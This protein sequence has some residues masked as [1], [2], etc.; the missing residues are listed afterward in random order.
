MQEQ[1]ALEMERISKAFP[2][3]RALNEVS[4][5]V[6]KGTV[7][8]LMGENGAGKST[9]MKILGG[10]Y[11]PDS[12]TIRL[13][14]KQ[15]EMF[16]PR[17]SLKN[18]IS[19]IHQELTSVF[20]MTV[21]E[22]VYLGR[23]PR[24]AN[25]WVNEKKM[26]EDLRKLMQS[27]EI[28]V[29]PKAKMKQLSIAKMQLVEI[30]KAISYNSE[31]IIM[32]EPTSAITN[33]EVDHL[34]KIIRSLTSKGVSIIYISHKMDEIFE[35][36]DDITVLRDGEWVG[37]KAAKDLTQQ[38]LI[39]MMV[40]R[41]L[42]E[43]FP[44]KV[45]EVGEKVLEVKNLSLKGKFHQVSFDLRKGEIL[46]IAGLVGAGRS[47]VMECLFGLAKPDEGEV[48][49]HGKKVDIRS[50][51]E[52]KENHLA[53]ITEDRKLTG[54]F[55]PHSV[56]DN[57]IAASMKKH[58]KGPFMQERKI[59]AV[60]LQ[61]KELLGIKTPN[62]E[63]KVKNLSGGNQQKVLIAKWL[64]TD[65]DIIILDEP[66]R[67]VDVGAKSEIHTLM[68]ELVAAGKS[69]IMISSEL[70]EI[71][72]MSDRIIVMHEGKIA[73]ELSREEATQ[74]LIMKYASGLVS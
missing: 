17:D 58:S 60:C 59:K 34:F 50:P 28:S 23:E 33:R 15:I 1:Y 8:A 53:F 68:G 63:Q 35:I 9:L 73:G 19:M 57:I 36:A 26:N 40:G 43:M 47:E 54:L 22:N 45:V 72:G 51:I 41:E 38:D 30:A 24:F 66:T 65:S 56:K 46:G 29:D 13:N 74:E 14:G 25:F 44:K 69:V 6:R 3:V 42:K 62:L 48:W 27:L 31:I 61:Q 32:D 67:G 37:S 12:G 16:S 7:H 4:L 52:A 21:A 49:V 70:P 5:K 20:E 64:L 10:L 2:G 18:G 11:R 71:L 39:S 55:L